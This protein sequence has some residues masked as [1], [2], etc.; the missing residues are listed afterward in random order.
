MWCSRRVVMVARGP[1]WWQ[2]TITCPKEALWLA[3][4]VRIFRRANWGGMSLS[5]LVLNNREKACAR[6]NF[7]WKVPINLI[8]YVGIDLSGWKVR[9]DFHE[10]MPPLA[11]IC[12][13]IF[14]NCVLIRNGEKCDCKW[15]SGIHNG[16]RQPFCDFKKKTCFDLKCWEMRSKVFF[17]HP[18]LLAVAI[19]STT[20]VA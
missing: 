1:M 8:F 16:H 13:Y 4:R 3:R 20:K 17:K 5:I 14:K 6:H 10:N 7:A 18:K 12:K 2:Q 9:I 19:L 15:S 11:T